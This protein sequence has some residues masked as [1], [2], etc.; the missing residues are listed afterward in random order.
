MSCPNPI[1]LSRALVAGI[2]DRLR[3]HLAGCDRCSA[4]LAAH[5]AI[6]AEAR[7]LPVDEPSPDRAQ[8]VRNALLVAARAPTPAPRPRLWWALGVAGAL[9]AA[10]VLLVVILPRSSS[11]TYRGTIHAQAGASY[12]RIG[13]APDEIVRLTDGTITVEVAALSPG[14]RFRVVTADGEVEVRGTAF[15]VTADHDHLRAV[16]VL[17]GR[18]EVRAEGST[19]RTLAAGER[20]ELGLAQTPSDASG[21]TAAI[22]NAVPTS[23]GATVPSGATSSTAK[24]ATG[25]SSDPHASSGTAAIAGVAPTASID[26]RASTGSSTSRAATNTSTS[27]AATSETTSTDPRAPAASTARTPTG[28]STSSSSAPGTP[29]ITTTTKGSQTTAPRRPNELLFER[30]WAALAKGDAAGA[31][32][33]FERAAKAAP[34]APLAEDAWFW[35]A[36]A[37]ARIKDGRATR[38]LEAFLAGY[39]RSPRAGEASAMLG[40]LVIDRD[41][42]RAEALFRAAAKDRGAAVRASAEKGLAVVAHRRAQ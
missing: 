20:W 37:L 8:S 22:A 33:T 18:V 14:E 13:A 10:A 12:V 30:G 23:S 17:H 15:D 31:A 5:A 7:R 24:I 2:D 38:A 19:R 39:P 21:S 34:S 42:D 41:V 35:R 6:A 32:A 9:A 11:P 4:E 40:W 25:A 26:P 1:E 3:A 27:R 29:S 28:A 36:S 16:R